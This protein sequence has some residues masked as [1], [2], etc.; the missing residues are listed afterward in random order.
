M[1]VIFLYS[2]NRMITFLNS[3]HTSMSFSVAVEK[4]KKLS[5]LDVEIICEQGKFATTVYRKSTFSGVYSNFESFLL[6]AY[7]FGMVYTLVYRCFYI[8]LNWTQFH[9]FWKEYFERMVTLETLL[10]N[11]LKSFEIIFI[12]SKKTYQKL[13]KSVCSFHS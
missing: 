1:S 7:K 4:E 8:C 13:K 11:V 6:S 2:S 10:T 9:F 3:C 5:F 12:L